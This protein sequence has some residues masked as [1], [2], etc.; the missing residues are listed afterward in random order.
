ML[1]IG[2]FCPTMNVCGGG[3][4]VAIAIANTLAQN[5]HKV[6]LFS[7]GEVNPS[8]IKSFFGETLEPSIETIK[9]PQYFRT[10][11]LAD[12]YQAIFHTY[13]AK[14]KCDIFVDT[15]TNCIFPWTNVCYIHFPFLNKYSFRKQFPYLTSPH[16]IQAG[17]IPHVLI[18]K[19]LASYDGKLVLANSQYTANEVKEYSKKTVEV[20]YPPFSSRIS[21]IGKNVTKNL[22]DNL[23]VTTSRFEDYKLLDRIPIIASHTNS[24]IKFAVIGRLYSKETLV[25]LQ[26]KV[27]KLGLDDRVKFYPDASAETKI[28]LLKK[29]KVYLHTMIGEHFGISIVEAMA[30]GCLPV[31]HNSGGMVEFVPEPYR[32]ETVQ[33]AASK[34]DYAISNWS[35]DKAVEMKQITEKFSISNFSRQFMAFFNEY[36]SNS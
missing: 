5:N 15:F 32:Y 6:I 28:A 27:K 2:V 26:T 4:F 35:P 24:N 21:A 3:E 34:I 9:Q 11:T 10:R 14:S 36:Y 1:K 16:L 20:L 19:N 23:V 25:S 12:F 22:R 31:V 13:I 33:E 8:A 17:A 7:N 29:A 30:L 18:E